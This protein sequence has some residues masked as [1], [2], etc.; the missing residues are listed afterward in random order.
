[1]VRASFS[2]LRGGGFN[3]DALT[4]T[5]PREIKGVVKKLR[6]GKAPGPGGDAINNILV[7]EPFSQSSCIF[8]L[9]VQRLSETIVFPDQMEARKCLY[10]SRPNKALSNPSNFRPICFLS[11]VT[12]LFERI[13]LRRFNEFLSNHNLFFKPPSW[14]L[15][16]SFHIPS[17]KQ[18]V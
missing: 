7:E 14:F 8:H 18:G 12:N 5:S 1:M 11:L 3:T 10:V 15:H 16:S 13:I 17:V 9:L 2:V 6:N 4:Y